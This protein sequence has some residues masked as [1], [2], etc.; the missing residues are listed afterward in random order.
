MSR[1]VLGRGIANLDANFS[2]RI[3]TIT[4]SAS[5][6]VGSASGIASNAIVSDEHENEV[7]I[8]EFVS[9][10][11]NLIAAGNAVAFFDESGD[12]AGVTDAGLGPLADNG[13]PADTMV[14]L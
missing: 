7:A 1:E 11:D 5:I 3:L 10:G 13:G 12:R 4:I 14:L 9:L 6:V 8:G 2:R